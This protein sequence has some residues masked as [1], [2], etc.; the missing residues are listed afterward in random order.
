MTEHHPW[1]RKD[2]LGIAE[3]SRDEITALLDMT[4]AFR[5]INQR[6]VKKVPTLRGKT[7]INLF[8]EPS[9][10]TRTSFE[11]AGKRL[12]ADVINISPGAS[13]LVKG[14]SL[15]DT[16]RNLQAM[17]PDVVVLRHPASG[18]AATIAPAVD[19]AIINAGD[20]AHEHPTQALLDA[21]TIREAC[22]RIEDVTV[23][24]VGDILHSRVA[25]SNI[26][27]LTRLGAH[28]IACGPATLV[29]PEVESLGASRELDLDRVLPECDVVMALRI[30]RER[31][32][33][34]FIPSLREYSK[35]Y[36]L[37]PARMKKARPDT[38]VLHPGPTNRGVEIDPAVADGPR[39][40]ILQQVAN[41][42]ALRMALLY[43]YAGGGHGETAA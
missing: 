15:L 23:V 27:A 40:L 35:L 13:S 5:E 2:L 19:A 10:R 32:T 12:S 11:L 3:L 4:A 28:V 30:Q 8:V 37:G 7:V 24:I 41:G 42:L 17:N 20:G 31:G 14:E 1:R 25:R 18:A 29:P 33:G 6:T 9:T 26:L 38:W 36:G 34:G 39:S 43:L 21:F 16:A 22:G